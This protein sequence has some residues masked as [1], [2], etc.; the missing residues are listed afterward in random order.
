LGVIEGDFQAQN[1]WSHCPR[2]RDIFHIFFDGMYK[3]A[4]YDFFILYPV[5]VKSEAEN[6]KNFS[7]GETPFQY[8]NVI[9]NSLLLMILFLTTEL[10][11]F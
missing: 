4:N 2:I 9:R 8:K 10:I 1:V 7:V 5:L 3:K 11:Y 6:A